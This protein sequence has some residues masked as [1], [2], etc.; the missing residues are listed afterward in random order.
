M[1]PT[2]M[3]RVQ[4]SFHIVNMELYIFFNL[5]E[6]FWAALYPG[7]RLVHVLDL[8]EPKAGDQLSCLG[9]RPVDDGAARAVERNTLAPR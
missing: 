9:E 7:D 1:F 8:P 5:K 6:N 2:E 4:S 3:F